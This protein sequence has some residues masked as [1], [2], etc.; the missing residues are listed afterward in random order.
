VRNYQEEIRKR[1][2]EN[3]ENTILFLETGAGKTIISILVIHHYL[4]RF[5]SKKVP[6]SPSFYS[7]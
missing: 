5:P 2:I 3:D 1:I 7:H 6:P 4:Q